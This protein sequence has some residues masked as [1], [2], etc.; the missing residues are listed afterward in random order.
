MNKTKQEVIEDIR[1]AI[2]QA[3]ANGFKVIVASDSE[4][5][6]WNAINPNH[7]EYGDT[8]EKYIAIGVWE[9]IEEDEAFIIPEVPF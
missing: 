5:N 9:P 3:E 1:K 7:L 6:N 4:G 8:N 2:I